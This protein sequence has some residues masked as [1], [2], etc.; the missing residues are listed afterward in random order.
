MPRISGIDIPQ[1]KRIEVALTYIYGIGPTR[2]R[3]ILSATGIN[4]DKRAK[5]LVGEEIQKL[6]KEIGKFPIE[7]DL[8]KQIRDSIERLK[9]IG[10]YRGVRHSHNLPVRGQR[11]RTN[12]RTKRGKRVTIG[13]LK[14]EEAA[15][16]EQSKK[17]GQTPT[18]QKS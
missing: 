7:G 6:A 12:A 3:E 13:A 15:K 4:P 11:T 18:K 1:N 17:T 8:K 14:K 16:L 10:S 9:H 2:T 5:D